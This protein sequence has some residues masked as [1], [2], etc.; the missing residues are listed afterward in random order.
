MNIKLKYEI[1]ANLLD[2]QFIFLIKQI[3]NL[4]ISKELQAQIIFVL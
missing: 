2:F 4:T 3:I 1:N